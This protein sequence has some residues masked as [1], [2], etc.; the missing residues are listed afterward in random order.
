[1]S[2]AHANAEP[3]GRFIEVLG[4]SAKLARD[5]ERSQMIFA[6]IIVVAIAVAGVVLFLEH[7]GDPKALEREYDSRL[8]VKEKSRRS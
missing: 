4:S 5:S 2:I 6:L 7:L 8:P 1:M 3:R